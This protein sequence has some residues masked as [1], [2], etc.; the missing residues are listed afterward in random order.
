[1]Y[2]L[3]HQLRLQGWYQYRSIGFQSCHLYFYS[4][5]KKEDQTRNMK[6]L[7]KLLIISAIL[8]G[9]GI[10]ATAIAVPIHFLTSST[11]IPTTGK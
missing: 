11:S 6:P 3:F 8:L 4:N 1:M 9:C 5:G 7:M 2:H 10:V